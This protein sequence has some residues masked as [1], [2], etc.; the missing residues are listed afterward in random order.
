MEKG[1]NIVVLKAAGVFSK[2]TNR[3]LF[4]QMCQFTTSLIDITVNSA[5]I[6]QTSLI[7][8]HVF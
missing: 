1:L 7:C 3:P 8:L 4:T 2:G 5:F 6:F